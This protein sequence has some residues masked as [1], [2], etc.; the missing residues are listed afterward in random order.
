MVVNDT[1][2]TFGV[3]NGF[4]SYRRGRK[5]GHGWMFSVAEHEFVK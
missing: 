3:K 1:V 5:S 4:A 2:I